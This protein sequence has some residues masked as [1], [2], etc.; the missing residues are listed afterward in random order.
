[1]N[2]SAQRALAS[3]L[4]HHTPLIISKPCDALHQAIPARTL[5]KRCVVIVRTA[6]VD[7][8][9]RALQKQDA[10]CWSQDFNSHSANWSILAWLCCLLTRELVSKKATTGASCICMQLPSMLP[11][12][13]GLAAPAHPGAAHVHHVTRNR[14]FGDPAWGQVWQQVELRTW[15]I[16]GPRAAHSTAVTSLTARIIRPVDNHAQHTPSVTALEEPGAQIWVNLMKQP[17]HLYGSGK[18]SRGL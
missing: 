12:S 16:S 5:P 18:R 9:A 14:Q 17:S 2:L 6:L 10:V 11:F 1:M 15:L 3:H 8:G 7:C 4:L 13:P